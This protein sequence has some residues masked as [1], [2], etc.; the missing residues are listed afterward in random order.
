MMSKIIGLLLFLGTIPFA[1]QSKAQVFLS[2]D[3]NSVSNP[4]LPTGWTS[5]PGSLW[6]SGV[7]NTITPSALSGLNY[8]LNRPANMKA[9]GI[10]GTQTSADGAIISSPTMAIPAGATNAI[11]LFD[12]AYF[13]IQTND[14]PPRTESLVFMV[15]TNGGTT[16]S[17][18]SFV[19]PASNPGT[20]PWETQSLPMGSY[21]GQRNL[22]IGFR[23]RNEGGVLI[24]A[25]LDN[26]KLVNG[27]DGAVISVYAG[28]HPDPSTGIGYQLA[29]SGTVLTGKVRNTGATAINSY[30]IK[31][32]VGSGAV[33]SSPLI[34]TP[35][36]PLATAD[37][38]AGLTVSIP[39]SAS[40]PIKAWIEASGDVD[41]GNDTAFATTIGV[42][43]F[44]VKRPVFEEGTGTWCGWCPRGAVFMDH[45]A[46]THSGGVAAQIAVHNNDPMTLAAYDSYMTRYANAYPN[47]IIDRAVV[48]DPRSIDTA[49]ATAQNNFG[50]AEFTLGTP[51]VNGSTVSVPVTIKPVVTMTNPKLALVITESNVTGSGSN[52]PQNNYYTG[53]GSGVMGGWESQPSEVT[54]VRFHFVA[55][56]ITP[57]PEGNALTLPATLMAGT[58]YN[59]TLTASLNSAWKVND[60][61][62]LALFLNG[63]NGSVMNSA[64]TTL[65]AL[66]PALG[67][68]TAI[69]NV[70]KDIEQVAV[71][72]NPTAGRSYLNFKLKEAA[73]TVLTVSDITGRN[74]LTLTEQMQPG[75][76]TLAIETGNFA[77]G[78]YLIHLATEKARVVR[79]LIIT[80]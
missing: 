72:P 61:Q 40:Y 14:T 58:T 21:A 12:V 18:I 49:F 36:A 59:A 50:F 37:F 70:E 9:V 1:N 17:D 4:G 15:S 47:L 42:P 41:P 13:N 39:A 48:K 55:R 46:V 69:A 7:P 33:Q 25:V 29:G 65:P 11:L 22:K 43:S 71:Y 79:K 57:S 60:L 54:D 20:A 3:F 52:W 53:G 63:N 51:V 64:F 56:N 74:L 38:P 35:L 30:Y 76:N 26:V 34:S 8:S 73:K 32:K 44:P 45:F 23:Y 66:L 75:S 62:Y 78:T 19:Y 67:N 10:D 6:K 5:T 24:G 31:Y 80:R 28:D 16:W 77:A 68:G 27:N 2:E